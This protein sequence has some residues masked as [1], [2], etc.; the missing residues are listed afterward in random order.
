[1]NDVIHKVE[2]GLLGGFSVTGEGVHIKI[3]ASPVAEMEPI[4]ITA[5]RKL[6]YIHDKLGL[7][8][9]ADA[10]MDSIENGAE[11]IICIPVAPSVPG[12][13]S[14]GMI[15]KAETS[16]D[17]TLTGTPNNSFQVAV[18]ITGK[19][20]LNVAAFQYSING[21]YSYSDEASVPLSG[22]YELPDTGLKVTFTLADNQ[23]F[24]V[25]DSFL[26]S[27]AAPELTNGDIIGGVE[28][29]KSLK[30]EAEL[31]HIVGST[32]PDT[33]AAVSVLQEALMADRH[34]PL[35]FV[36]EA[37][38]KGESE[39]MKEY[40][41]AL[42]EGRKLVKNYEMQV[43]P[44]RMMYVGMDNITRDRN[45]A[46]IICGLY[47][48][49]GVH[50]S[51]GETGAISLSED[52]VLAL[53][54]EGINDEDI[55]ELDQMGYLTI[56]QYDGLTGY[57]IN[58]AR[59]MGP[60]GTDY[61]YAEDVRVLNKI[62]RETRKKALLELQSDV[63]LEN[64][65]AD[66]QAKAAFIKQPLDEMVEAKEISAAEIRIPEGTAENLS[67]T[68]TLSLQVRYLQRG[69]IRNIEIDLGKQNPYAG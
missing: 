9:L 34:K 36:L 49:T 38:E 40:K 55:D 63:D 6:D 22:E 45:A 26:W 61:P 1:M 50:K 32:T 15:N 14:P 33:W 18:R 12:N 11:K 21:G 19:G 52:K 30:I 47:A 65:E 48:K 62:I 42:E 46:G 28:S 20:A 23:A 31:V 51:I 53:L 4:V 16:G 43:V 24:E 39:T 27:T 29:I 57:Y 67:R 60:E 10:V 25:G 66:L 56:R 64:P 68:G 35:L 59:M 41:A 37:F 8:P 13:I 17:I 3:G 54:P 5:A 58:N 44:A 69:I 7:S 2:D